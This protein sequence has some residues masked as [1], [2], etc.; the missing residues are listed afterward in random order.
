MNFVL[1]YFGFRYRFLYSTVAKIK[2]CTQRGKAPKKQ[3]IY[4]MK[5]VGVCVCRYYHPTWMRTNTSSGSGR[6]VCG[7]GCTAHLSTLFLQRKLCHS[8]FINLVA[9]QTKKKN[10]RERANYK[11]N[12]I[13]SNLPESCLLHCEMQTNHFPKILAIEN[14]DINIIAVPPSHS[15]HFKARSHCSE[16]SSYV[17]VKVN[18]GANGEREKSATH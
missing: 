16:R 10:T 13:F 11:I 2:I 8:Y 18:E 5:L 15:V 12:I 9:I 7:S 6:G 3:Q 14:Q 4:N 17:Q 1:F